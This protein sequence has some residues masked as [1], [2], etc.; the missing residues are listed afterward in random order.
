MT[1][2]A[3]PPWW[4]NWKIMVPVW[5]LIVCVTW[6][7][8]EARVEPTVIAGGVVVVGLV[9]NAFAWL[10]GLL[11]LVPV[12][13]P[14]VVGLVTA[15]FVTLLSAVSSIVAYIAIK[16]GYTRDMLTFKG[17]TIALMIGIVM[18]FIIGRLV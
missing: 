11:G 4:R 14:V 6:L 15:G 7:A 18:G 2:K 17:V 13:G 1:A 12:V 3:K 5:A 8:I 16:R 9:T 10:L